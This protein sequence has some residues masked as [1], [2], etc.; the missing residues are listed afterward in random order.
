MQNL[1]LAGHETTLISALHMTDEL[2][3]GDI[4]MKRPLSLEGR[5]EEI[6]HRA[7]D[8]V[9]DMIEEIVETSPEPYPQEG[10]VT[11][12]I[13]RRPEQSE[14][15]THGSLD[16]LYDHIRML[17]APTYPLAFVDYGSFRLEFSRAKLR[18]G[19]LSAT[20]SIS[21]RSSE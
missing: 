5:A 7:A 15:P 18:D 14:L 1:I 20:V 3:A 12:F 4:Y 9:F 17:D 6:Y 10:D 19:R 13:R 16:H 11:K 2:D 8:T 21:E